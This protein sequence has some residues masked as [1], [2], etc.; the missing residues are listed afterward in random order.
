MK[1]MIK[2][3]PGEASWVTW[4]KKRIDNNLNFLAI[5][6]GPTGSSKSYTDLSIA[7]QLDPEFDANL[8]IAFSFKELMQII[9]KFNGVDKDY[10]D[11]EPA[12]DSEDEETV[13][14]P[15][16]KT[17]IPL[18]KRSYKV[19]L[20][21]EVQTAVNRREWQSKINK[22]F[23]YLMSTFRHQNIIVLFNAPYSDYFDS[24]VMKLIHAKFECQGWSKRTNKSYVRPKA[25][26][27]NDKLSK[28][29]EHNLIVIDK[30]KAHKFAGNWAVPKPPVHITVPYE[31]RKTEFTNKMNADMLSELDNDEKGKKEQ[32]I[33][34]RKSL[35][36]KQKEIME[37]LANT[38]EVNRYEIVGKRLNISG[39]S[40]SC[41]RKLA[42]QKGYH[43]EEFVNDDTA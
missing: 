22:M 21:E 13:I 14:S 34:K 37:I 26:Q 41:R 20:F 31:I 40:I 8:Q 1:N 23:L 7:Y 18:H 12:L 27:Y 11:E 6:T 25:L 15:T 36:A 33:D 2:K 30:G 17:I 28:F 10:L 5:T 32:V 38:K 35:T 4:I 24:S 16:P 43:L 42:E 39:N 3:K 9:N 19:A 29:Y